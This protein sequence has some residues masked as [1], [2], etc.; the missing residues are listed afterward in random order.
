MT[1]LPG[2]RIT[3]E[4]QLRTKRGGVVWKNEGDGYFSGIGSG[5]LG[6]TLV[7]IALPP[8]HAAVGMKYGSLSPNVNGGLT[9]GDGHVFGWDYGHFENYSTPQQ[10]IQDAL[11]YFHNYKL[12]ATPIEAPK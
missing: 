8:N 12:T 9:F 10:D 7:Y 1:N 5:P 2:S 3:P 4:M 6:V 11:V